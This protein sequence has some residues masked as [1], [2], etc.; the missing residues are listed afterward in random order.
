[1]IGSGL[2]WQSRATV[3]AICGAE[4]DVPLQRAQASGPNFWVVPPRSS[5]MPG[6]KVEAMPVPTAEQVT[7]SPKLDQSAGVRSACSAA[8]PITPGM[9]AGYILTFVPLLPALATMSTSGCW[10]CTVCTA[11]RRAAGASSSTA[12]VAMDRLMMFAP[13]FAAWMI[14]LPMSWTVAIPSV[15]AFL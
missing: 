14:A 3:P 6:T 2:S 11:V 9:A 4:N 12:G 13:S 5:S 1:M 8:T 15:S 10:A 7:Q